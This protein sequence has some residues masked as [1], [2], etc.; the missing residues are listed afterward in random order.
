MKIFNIILAALILTTARSTK[1]Y[2]Q[3]TKILTADKHN[4][5]GLVYTLPITSLEIEV[6]AKRTTR[7]AGP[8]FQYAKKFIGTDK[9]IKEDSESWEITGIDVKRLGIPDSNNRYLMQL[10]NGATTFISV[11]E[12]GMLL[13]INKQ[14]DFAPETSSSENARQ[15]E[16]LNMNE[17]LQYV[18]EDFI[19]SQSSAKRAQM[20]AESL[21]EIREAKVSLT[22]GTAESMPKDGKQLELMLN[23]LQ[24]QEQALTAAFIGI[25]ETTTVKRKYNFTPE[26]DGKVILFRMSDFAGFV[27]SDDYAGDPVY[28]NVGIT[29]KG[30]LPKDAK[31]EEKKLPKDAVMYNIP[32]RALISISHLGSTLYSEELDFAQFGFKFGLSPSLFSVKKNRSYAV[33]DP[34]TGALSE[35]GEDGDQ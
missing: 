22:R 15:S 5:Y 31:G 17:Y 14:T 4:E 11:A 9:V 3:S 23:S 25:T 24:H 19:A 12:D 6:T 8:Y 7:Q 28:I 16:P 35:I 10:K 34:V 30:E 33:F 13:S 32:G 20:L 21:M 29:S 27:G 18:D 1:S 26:K 2:G